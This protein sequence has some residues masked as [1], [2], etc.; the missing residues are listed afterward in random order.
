MTDNH[1]DVRAEMRALVLRDDL[2]EYLVN[3]RGRFYRGYSDDILSIDFDNKIVELSR[4]GLMQMLPEG[5]FYNEEFLREATN[6]DDLKH[7]KEVLLEQKKQ[8]RV[9]FDAFDTAFFKKEFLL[10][11]TIN[12]IESEQEAII[13]KD[14]YGI[15]IK[16]ERN[17]LIR[18]LARLYFDEDAVKGNIKLIPLFVKVIIGSDLYCKVSKHV[19]NVDSSAYYTK[20]SFVIIIEG[21]SASEYRKKM[22][23]YEEFFYYLE[24]WFLPYDCDVDF[25]IKDPHQRFVLGE[26]MT[27]DYNTQLL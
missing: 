8:Y 9:F 10:H 26:S 1:K 3:K 23:E 24:Q 11:S 15:D 25:C 18:K 5:M 4:N 7:R 13:L 2:S 20:L 6:D 22:D 12:E 14:F 19:V 16:R 27:L 17:P 21:L